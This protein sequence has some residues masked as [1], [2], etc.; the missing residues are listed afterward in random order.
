MVIIQQAEIYILIYSV[1]ESFEKVVISQLN[2]E[3]YLSLDVCCIVTD[4]R[5][6]KKVLV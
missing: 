1:V 3:L 5:D 6:F 4:C 2:W